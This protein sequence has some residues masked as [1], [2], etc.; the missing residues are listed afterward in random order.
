MLAS[1]SF[2]WSF[3]GR[4]VWT[5]IHMIKVP[6][7]HVLCVYCC[8][9][10]TFTRRPTLLSETGRQ[11][12]RLITMTPLTP[13]H[14]DIEK[15]CSRGSVCLAWSCGFVCHWLSWTLSLSLCLAL[16]LSAWHSGYVWP[17]FSSQLS[18][19]L[20]VCLSVLLSSCLPVL[21]AGYLSVTL[22]GWLCFLISAPLLSCKLLE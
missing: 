4:L 13:Q 9:G 19:C 14:E 1:V 6:H 21:L 3:I 18:V 15:E 7:I 5:H 12:I 20:S 22:A 11:M 8:G 2:L 17:S 10:Y 16:C